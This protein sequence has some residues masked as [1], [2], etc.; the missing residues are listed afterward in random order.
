M[1]DGWEKDK[2]GK[3]VAKYNGAKYLRYT[4]TLGY[5]MNEYDPLVDQDALTILNSWYA[6]MDR[7]IENNELRILKEDPRI[8]W[9]NT[10]VKAKNSGKMLEDGNAAVMRYCYG[11]SN[12]KVTFSKDDYLNSF[13]TTTWTTVL[14]ELNQLIG[15]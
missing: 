5:D 3:Y 6:D 9:A 2:D 7:A 15:K 13:K 12:G 11:Q 8:E 14:N 4:V 1:K 10:P